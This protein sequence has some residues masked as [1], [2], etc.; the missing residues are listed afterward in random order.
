MKMQNIRFLL[1]VYIVLILVM[2]ILPY[3]SAEGYSMFKH[4]TSHLG[5]QN[6]PN[7]W[8][9]NIVF[10][11]LGIACILEG[12]FHLRQYW[13][14]KILLTIFGVG[15]ILVGIFQHA[16]IVEEIPYNLS[17][18]KM[19][20]LFATV[21]GLSFTI[22]AISAAFIEKTNTKR[23]LALLVGL[24]ATGLSILMFSVI[25]FAGLWQR[26]MFIISFA[27]LIFFFEGMRIEGRKI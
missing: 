4:T 22:F 18:D 3:Y 5:A 8:I 12:L 6:T 20:S 26:L 15:L 1:P 27:W 9:M 13:V 14:H 17:E 21:V 24:I 2:L 16:P 25:D 19:H 10:C 23:I 11:L 7:A